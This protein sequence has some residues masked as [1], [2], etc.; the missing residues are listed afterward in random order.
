M[1]AEA[2]KIGERLAQV[3]RQP[4]RL[5][6]KDALDAFRLLQAIET[7]DLVRGFEVHRQD[8]H[9]APVTIE[10]IEVY[11]AHA[12]TPDGRIAR[13]AADAARGDMSVAPACAALVTDL[14]A[15]LLL[16]RPTEAPAG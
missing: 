7:A 12:S 1:T 8:E 6:E 9:A 5:K 10:A 11:R 14:L 3:D 13:L 2:I 4:D 15:A 16:S